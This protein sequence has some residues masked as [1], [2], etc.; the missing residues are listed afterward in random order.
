MIKNLQDKLLLAFI[1]LTN[2]W[3]IIISQIFH[4]GLD[5]Y[6]LLKTN[7]FQLFV[8]IALYCF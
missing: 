8:N 5:Q 6:N 3:K 1:F 2:E 7:L 4:K